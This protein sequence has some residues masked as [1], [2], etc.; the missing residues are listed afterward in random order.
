[1]FHSHCLGLPRIGPNR[2][3]KFALEKFWKSQMTADELEQ[4]ARSLRQ[5]NWEK[6]IQSGLDFIQVGDFS[7]YDQVA[8][9]IQRLGCVPKRFGK[10]TTNTLDQY[11]NM[12]RG[13]DTFA[14]EMTKWFDTNYHYM[15]PEFDQYTQFDL[16]VE[17]LLAQVKE[18]TKLNHPI[19][20]QLI[21]PVTFLHLGKAKEPHFDVLSLLDQLLPCYHQLLKTL[22]NEGVQWVQLDEPVLSTDL[23]APWQVALERAYAHL[24]SVSIKKMVATY[25]DSSNGHTGLLCRLPVQA[26]HLD[27]IRAPEDLPTV[28]D[29]L[30]NYRHLSLGLIDGRNIWKTDLDRAS[31]LIELCI[32]QGRKELWLAP[33]CSLLHVPYSFASETNLPEPVQNWLAGVDEKLLELSWLK[34]Q[35]KAKYEGVLVDQVTANQIREHQLAI[36]SRVSHPIV[37]DEEVQ[38]RQA[39]ITDEHATRISPFKERQKAQREAFKLPLL[40]TT[41]IGSFPQTPTLRSK[42]AQWRK[43]DLSESDY[44]AYLKQEIQ[45]AI[46]TQEEL[47][48]DVLVHGEAERTDMVE[49]FGQKLKGFAFTEK[50]WVQSYG[51]RCVKPPVLY[52]DVSRPEA[53]TVELTHY[54]QSLSNKP[55]KG[56]LTGP[57]TILQWSFVRDDQPRQ[58]TAEQIALAIADE[59]LDLEKAGIGI[60][61]I[62]EPAFREGLPIRHSKQSHYLGWAS[63]AFRLASKG[64]KDTTQIHTHMCY[65]EFNDIIEHIAS[66]D[67]DVITIET[68]R[69]DMELLRAFGE[70]DYPN[71][72]GPGVYDIHSPKVPSADQMINLL[73]KA[74]KVLPV[75]NL[76]VNPDCG[77]KTRD[78]PET[79]AALQNMVLA[80]Q[81]LRKEAIDQ[82]SVA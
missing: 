81:V 20:V 70:F 23:S 10:Q 51:S 63:R 7:F 73:R 64:V 69:S 13:H 71:E 59:V 54:A 66:L 12:V 38:T 33:S 68:S 28:L 48:L 35:S 76:W 44:Q 65:S 32:N 56:M 6:Q 8:D 18:A 49:Y 40:P 15:V 72:I 61:Q 31:D 14:L 80:A 26:I 4:N 45:A 30:P 53:M 19:K 58:T 75:E 42:R 41:T 21:G 29:W 62:D 16:N 52:G 17:D 60:I 22:A 9:H 55:V 2:E 78:W 1:M 36:T 77:L 67:A 46:R 3:L 24:Q 43:H 5:A 50:A 82:R 57:I 11:F 79:K 34:T 27:C 47:G 74:S 25:F 37:K 39:A